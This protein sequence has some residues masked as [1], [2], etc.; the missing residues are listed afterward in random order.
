[1]TELEQAAG[2]R[3]VNLRGHAGQG[4]S[5]RPGRGGLWL[6]VL[7]PVRAWRGGRLVRPGTNKQRALLGVLALAANTPVHRDLLVD[8]VWSERPPATAVTLVQAYVSGLR[9]LLDPGRLPRDR[10]G[11]LQPVGACY[12]LRATA[13]QLDLLAFE[14]LADRARAAG[15]RGDLAAACEAYEQALEMWQGQPVADIAVLRGHSFS[16]AAARR[17]AAVV[18]DYADAACAAGRPG[19]V[20]PHLWE[21]T[22]RDPLD[23]KAHARLMIA[24]A[25]SGQQAS[26]LRVFEDLRHRLDDQLGVRPGPDLTSAHMRILRQQ[27]PAAGQPAYSPGPVRI[28]PRQL[29]AAVPYFAGRDAGLE[30]LTGLLDQAPRAGGTVIAAIA[31]MAG[32]GKTALAIH[33]SHRVIGR[34]PDGQLYADL[35]GFDPAGEPV[36]P[37]AAIRGFLDA[38]GV[39]AEQIPAGS[40][41]R[42]GLYRSLLARKRMLIVL[43]NALDEQQ[44]RPL[45]PASPGCLVVVT[46]RT[47]LTGLAAAEGARQLGLDV[48][49]NEEARLVLAGRLGKQRVAAEPAAVAELISLCGRLPLAL[50]V[51]AARGAVYPGGSLAAL[52]ADLRAARDRLDALGSGDPATSVR[53]V[54]GWS[55][56]RLTVPAARVFRLLGL[57]PGH[58]ITVPAAASLAGLRPEQ[59]RDLLR[60][61]TRAHLLSEAA[62]GLYAFHDLVRVYAARQTETTDTE[63]HR[64]TALT[65]LFDYY[66]A[67]AATGNSPV[68]HGG[69]CRPTI[70]RRAAAL[71]PLDTPEAART[72]LDERAIFV[73]V[74]GHTATQDRPGDTPRLAT[75]LSRY[76]HDIG[77]RYPDAIAEHTGTLQAAERSGD[78]AAQADALWSRG[79]VE[80]RG[81]QHRQAMDQLWQA[82]AIYRELGD[83]DGAARTFCLL[84]VACYRQAQYQAT[85]G[86]L[87][88]VIGLRRELGDRLG[89]AVTLDFLGL[90]RWREGR[91]HQAAS[92][93]R[94]ALALF[95]EIGFRRGEAGALA[96]LGAVLHRLGRYRRA[97][98]LCEQARA[99]FCE[100]G[101]RDGAA[102][103]LH[104]LGI[105][106]CAQGRYQ[107]AADHHQRALTMFRELDDRPNQA[108]ALNGLGK[109]LNLL[110]RSSQARSHHDSALSLACQLG[111]PYLEA[112]SHSGLA[113]AYYAAGDLDRARQHWELVLARYA[114]A[115]VPEAEQA[116]ARLAALHGLSRFPVARPDGP[117]L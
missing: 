93:H 73:A 110:G 17:L 57:H 102:G 70:A 101:D 54:I 15:S 81:G 117:A 61:L 89:E 111:D 98:D 77:A 88:Q 107:D 83:R 58:D 18:C 59:A 116:R 5:G 60:E 86:Y 97:A 49:S 71:P 6:Q 29:P 68:P 34:F 40:Q 112:R 53:A 14:R 45:L 62:P 19:M 11:L 36:E 30:A 4:E 22:G 105:C 23:E 52:A 3:L 8:A 51:I 72:W 7:G 12:L 63:H 39:P 28:V 109:V 43:D 115:G 67:A 38:L 16:I 10:A 32:V 66:L 31:G 82:L 35:R 13:R 96:N 9:R 2:I 108:R 114:D 74:A 104:Y 44:V 106:L 47:Q 26:A 76:Y 87:R 103:A 1:M 75:I 78:R 95:R 41:A 99:L 113:D 94:Q 46:S 48:L 65:R 21:L 25:G 50:A 20:M 80:F 84:G 37:G 56:R 64:R 24:L 69:Q 85:A 100:L 90:V 91:Y 42:T 55:Y 79:I 27:V 92:R 33:W